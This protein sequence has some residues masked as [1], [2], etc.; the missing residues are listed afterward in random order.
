L[1]QF[2]KNG[3]TPVRIGLLK[4]KTYVITGA[5]SSTGFE[6]VRILVSKGSKVVT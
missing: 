4:M 6:A 5:T 2:E 3:W 1:I